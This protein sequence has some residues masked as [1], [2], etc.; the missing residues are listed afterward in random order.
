MELTVFR[1]SEMAQNQYINTPLQTQ[2]RAVKKIN[3]LQ[4][5]VITRHSD[6]GVREG[7]SEETR[8]S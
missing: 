3:K 8:R 7:I 1:E 5:Q 6:R 2:N 4:G